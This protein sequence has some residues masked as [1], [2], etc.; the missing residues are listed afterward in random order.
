MKFIK[1]DGGKGIDLQVRP[2]FNNMDLRSGESHLFLFWDKV[3]RQELLLL[4]EET[5]KLIES[6][7]SFPEMPEFMDKGFKRQMGENLKKVLGSGGGK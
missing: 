6:K 5:K 3:G 2:G 4:I 1:R 7:E